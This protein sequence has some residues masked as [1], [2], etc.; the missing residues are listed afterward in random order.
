MKSEEIHEKDK[1]NLKNKY[2]MSRSSHRK[3]ERQVKAEYKHKRDSK[4]FSILSSQSSSFF[5]SIRSS[6]QAKSSKIQKLSV[7]EKTYYGENVPDGFYDSLSFLKSTDPATLTQSPTFKQFTEDYNN[8]L[9]LCSC[10]AKLPMLSI[11][12]ASEILSGI[13]CDVRD[14]YS[15]TALHFINAGQEGLHHFQKLL[16]LLIQDLNNVAIEEFNAVHAIILYKGHDKDRCSERSYRTISTCPFLAKALDLY[17]RDLNLNMWNQDQAETQY[18]GEGSS[19]ELAAVLLTECIQFSLYS[20]RKP[21]FVLYLDAKSA[22]DVVL[23]EFLVKNLYF[24]GTS[25]PSIIYINH[26]LKNRSTYVEW[27][28]RLMGPIRDER[29]LEQGGVNSSDFYKIFGKDQLVTA[30]QSGLGVGL[31]VITVAAIGQADDT[32]LVSNDINDIQNLLNL[33]LEFCRKYCVQLCVEKTHLQAISTSDLAPLADYAKSVS[34]VNIH[35][36]KIG[37]VD[38]AEHVGILRSVGGNQPNLLRRIIAHKRALGQVLHTGIAK[39]HHGNPAASLKV[40]QIYGLPVLMS[41]LA[42]LV[43]LKSDLN[44]LNQHYKTTLQN[45]MRL[46]AGTPSC[47]VHFLAGSLPG[48]ALLHLRF[49]SLFGMITRLQGSM[50]H[51]HAIHVLVHSKTSTKSWFHQIRNI[52]L[53]YKLPHPVLLLQEPP[54]KILFKT[55][56]TKAVISFWEDK[57]RAEASLLSS[58][59]HFQPNYMSLI[60]PHPLWLTAGASSYEVIKATIQA[61]MLSGRYRTELFCSHWSQN[62][63]GVCLLSSCNGRFVPEDLPHILRD[64]PQLEETRLQLKHFTAKY[65]TN[66]HESIT[67]IVQQFTDPSHPQNIQFLLDCSSLPVVI[68]LSQQLGGDVLF[69]LF[70]IS[71]TWCYSLHRERLKYLGKF[72]FE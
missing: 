9:H 54:K 6:K 39:G 40:N 45:L 10:G 52:C 27:E 26:R 55:M 42:A 14:L 8:I 23:R 72:K 50:L 4:L 36:E 64:C 61:K 48:L 13:K 51:R 57:L 20:I 58:L 66:L 43:M 21:L 53:Q 56:V 60:K 28:K 70:H 71:R 33:S 59:Q 38:S 68:T 29:G 44:T 32:A 24:S 46:H 69:H 65:S 3:L 35:G 25:E 12:K 16:N 17:V 31:G 11:D 2:K 67:D 41:G 47:V 30:Q 7:R 19:H 18:Q 63:A 15:I 1:L 34:P 62:K 37:F 22:F 5:K 49:L